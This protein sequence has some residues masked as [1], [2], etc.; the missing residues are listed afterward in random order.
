M[1]RT[2]R[3]LADLAPVDVSLPRETWV[4]DGWTHAATLPLKPGHFLLRLRHASG[5]FAPVLARAEWTG[6]MFV[7]V[8]PQVAQIDDAALGHAGVALFERFRDNAGQWDV[9][10]WRRDSGS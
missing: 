7:A 1:I 4:G 6:A 10:A 9:T 3:S 2:A 5:A 8:Q